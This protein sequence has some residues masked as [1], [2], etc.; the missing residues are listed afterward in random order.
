MNNVNKNI[1]H[2]HTSYLRSWAIYVTYIKMKVVLW[3]SLFY[4]QLWVT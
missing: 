4:M 1:R 3:S 2:Q